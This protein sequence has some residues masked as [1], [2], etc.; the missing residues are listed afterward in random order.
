MD[1]LSLLSAVTVLNRDDG[2]RFLVTDR[3]DAVSSLLAGSRFRRVEAPG[4]FHLYAER[5]PAML[6]GRSVIVVSSHADCEAG[7]TGCFSREEGKDTLLGT[8]DNAI[9]NAAIV[10]LMLSDR[11]RDD[12]IVAFT[13]DEEAGCAGAADLVRFL[14]ERQIRVRHLFVL[15][16]TD[17]AWGDKA[18][19]TIENNFWH[20]DF[21][22]KIV[23]AAEGF[24]W[25]WRFVPSD[26]ARVPAF[27]R[28]DNLIS[29]EA[30]ED[31]SWCYDEHGINCCSVCLP[32]RG[33]MHSDRGVKA[34]KASLF[35]YTEALGRLLELR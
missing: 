6:T 3:L 20:D 28:K 24:P 23:S 29:A 7:I 13:G 11:L 5:D 1:L 35:H 18:D 33:P 32:V 9:T 17:M 14:R 22:K 27:V 2:E 10:W 4:L 25:T 19:F 8:Y 21:G 34:R 15:D 16:V 31:E 30:T 26:P 12:V